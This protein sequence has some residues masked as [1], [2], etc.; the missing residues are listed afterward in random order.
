MSTKLL[1]CEDNPGDVYLIEKSFA[2]SKTNYDID[3][4]LNGDRVLPYLRQ[5]NQYQSVPRPDLIILDLNL[6][7]KHGFEILEEIKA[8][9]V[10]RTIPVVIL[11]SSRSRQDILKG[12]ELQASCYIV[13]PAD[14]QAFLA[15]IEQIE[16]FW[17][18]L[19]ELP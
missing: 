13:K 4:L 15:A 3:N 7:G 9:N 2:D 11:S 14:L 18:S 16:R 6:P 19:V 17:L 12:Y 10:L 8:D 5:E 1:L